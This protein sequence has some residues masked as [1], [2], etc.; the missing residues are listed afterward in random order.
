MSTEYTP[1]EWWSATRLERYREFL[2]QHGVT[3]LSDDSIIAH[4]VQ[5][6]KFIVEQFTDYTPYL[7]KGR[8]RAYTTL[9]RH[10]R[11]I[12][13]VYLPIDED[14]SSLCRDS[15]LLNLTIAPSIMDWICPF[16]TDPV[17]KPMYDTDPPKFVSEGHRLTIL[18]DILKLMLEKNSTIRVLA[19]KS[20]FDQVRVYVELASPSKVQAKLGAV[21]P[22]I[23]REAHISDYIYYRKCYLDVISIATWARDGLVRGADLPLLDEVA[24]R[25]YVRDKIG[26]PEEQVD[27]VMKRLSG[28][29]K[30]SPE[31]P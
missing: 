14:V 16:T 21:T 8:L 1:R 30:C 24:I 2:D 19:A 9:I 22:E 11:L 3:D 28:F 12:P 31:I 18:S 23:V 6:D 20:K 4:A 15:G 13:D 27:S 26:V 25:T 7:V 17:D 5:A 10:L 29:T